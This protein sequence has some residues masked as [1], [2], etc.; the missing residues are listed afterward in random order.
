MRIAFVL[1]LAA[2]V[3]SGE[4]AVPAK[5]GAAGIERARDSLRASRRPGTARIQAGDYLLDHSLEFGSRDP[6]GSVYIADPEVRLIGGARVRGWRPV[7]DKAVLALLSVSARRNAMVAT[8]AGLGAF[9]ARG[10]GH[11]HMPAHSELFFNGKRMTVSRWPN[12]E[13]TRIAEASDTDPEDDGHGRR[14]GRLPFGFRY[15]G[16]RP[17]GWK[18]AP[19]IWVHGY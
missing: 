14:I 1:G 9:Q 4:V 11:E 10:F 3:V 19:D 5:H 13:F 2:T 17:S 16:D 12:V 8:V 7:S 15:A 18:N 6:E